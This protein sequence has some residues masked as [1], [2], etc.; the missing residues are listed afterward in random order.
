M[1]LC[2][3]TAALGMLETLQNAALAWTLAAAMLL[4]GGLVYLSRGPDV[5]TTEEAAALL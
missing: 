5:V 3:V 4:L 1:L 2:L